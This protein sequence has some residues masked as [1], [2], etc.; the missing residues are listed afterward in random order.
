MKGVAVY[1]QIKALCQQYSY[2]DCARRLGIS[3][4]T[5]QKYAQMSMEEAA[6]YFEGVKR[7]SQFDEA[8]DFIID[9]LRRFPRIRAPKLLRKI[10][11]RYPSITA[12][13]RAL[14]NYI[15]PLRE[16]VCEGT[17][18]N[19]RYYEPVLDMQPGRQV[20]VD[21]GEDWV[22]RDEG[23]GRFKSYFV[24]FVFS[25]SRKKYA[26]FQ[27][28]FYDTDS[29]IDAHIAAFRYFGGIAE[30]YVYDQTK[31]VVINE[32]YREVWFNERFYQFA[33]Q[34]GFSIHVC[35]GYDPE[36]KGKVENS[37]RYI[38][39]DFLYGDYFE[40]VDAVNKAALGWLEEV[41]NHRIHSVTGRRP[42]E[43]FEEERLLL[44]PL[45]ADLEERPCRWADKTGL[46]SFEGNKYSVPH[47]YQRQRV[48]VEAF[49]GKLI[50][51]DRLS[52]EELAWYTLLEG[53]GRIVK[54][55]NHYRDYRKSLEELTKE[56][57]A[58]FEA[59]DS[60]HTLILRL[61]ADNVAIARDQL[62]GLMN[63]RKTYSDEIWQA[64][65]AVILQLPRLRIS[66]IEALLQK[67][68][69]RHHAAAAEAEHPEECSAGASELDRSLDVYMEVLGHA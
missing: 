21:I 40:N 52:G 4:N 6:P 62:R 20:Q 5:V 55:N 44:K 12:K 69:Q 32:R 63:L 50:I 56:A 1:H 15:V 18:G 36:S 53:S 10:R 2:R 31:L 37:I 34:C 48:W 42:E 23:G 65:L 47:L 11:E 17:A 24:S 60:S 7:P 51:R 43:M 68:Q 46:I 33:T 8:R 54:N 66:L 22:C 38:K 41:A 45:P 29:F 61:R 39:G 58:L 57:E 35:E 13:E 3:V 9:Q 26:T 67:Y 59:L 30:E 16:A 64:S 19:I 28:R 14:R 25:Y 49:E 27:A